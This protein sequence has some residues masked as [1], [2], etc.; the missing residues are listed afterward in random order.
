MNKHFVFLSAVLLAMS[1]SPAACSS[2]PKITP[3]PNTE[4]VSGQAP[5]VS[6][7]KAVESRQLSNAELNYEIVLMNESPICENAYTTLINLLNNPHI[8]DTQWVSN[9]SSQ[10]GILQSVYNQAMSLAPP[11]SMAD[12]HAKYLQALKYMSDGASSIIKG[13]AG[14]DNNLV[15]QGAQALSTGSQALIG[16]TQLINAFNDA[17]K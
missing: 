1:V 13:L 8:D 2:G 12:I 10:M 14:P 7:V 17:H 6:T 15:N 3:F 9:A 11:G 4:Y 5:V 16:V